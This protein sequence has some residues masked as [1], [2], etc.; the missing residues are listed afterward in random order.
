MERYSPEA[1]G[2]APDAHPAAVVRPAE[3]VRGK[4]SECIALMTADST[5]TI[6]HDFAKDV[7]GAIAAHRSRWS[8]PLGTDAR[9]DGSLC[10]RA[11]GQP[12]SP[13]W[14]SP[15][16]LPA[17]TRPNGASTGNASLTSYSP[18]FPSS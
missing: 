8:R 7:E 4:I 14:N 1:M 13:C 18:A 12:L 2:S 5:A 6:D 9:L 3:P 16:A 11:R 10:R 15:T 17:P